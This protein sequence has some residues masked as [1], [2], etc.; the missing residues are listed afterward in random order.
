MFRIE[1]TP[2]AFDDLRSL[3]RFD[4]KRILSEIEARL[5]HEPTV[6]TRNRKR[7]RP[8]RLAEWELRIDVFRVFYDVIVGDDVNVGDEAGIVK[9][10]AIGYKVGNDLFVHGEEFE[11]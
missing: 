3:R 8:N 1:L 6:E 9:V 2:E 7:L 5:P 4:Q 10:V 11:L